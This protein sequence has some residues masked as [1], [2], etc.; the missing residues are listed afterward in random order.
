VFAIDQYPQRLD[1]ARQGHP[2]QHIDDDRIETVNF[3]EENVYEYLMDSTG[4]RGPD[5]CIDAVGLESHG[6]T[7]DALYDRI[8]V[9]SRL[10]TDRIHVLRQAARA[11]RKNGTISIPGVYGGFADKF[12]IGAIFGKGVTLRS[13]QTHVHNYMKPL[14]ARIEKEEI[15]PS[16]V[17]SHR[18]NLNDAPKA[19]KNFRYHQ[20][21]YT[22]IVLS[23]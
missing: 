13:G 9:A 19:Y 22:K 12:P 11:V 21:E 5:A 17:I 6:T 1:L 23:P 7:L 10:A 16:L 3:K 20:N 15:H 8:K 18:Y 4:G 2:G 14:L